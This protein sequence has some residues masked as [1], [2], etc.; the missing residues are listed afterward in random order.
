MQFT[1]ETTIRF[2]GCC[3]AVLIAV[4]ALLSTYK[5]WRVSSGPSIEA[6][7]LEREFLQYS[8][9]KSYVAANGRVCYLPAA[10]ANFESK[11]AFFIA[12]YALAPFL[13]RRGSDC[14]FIVVDRSH[15]PDIPIPD[16]STLIGKFGREVFLLRKNASW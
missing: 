10:D 3:F 4:V 8:S 5:L 6:K 9:L 13:L 2:L 15:A 14:E 12:Q 7:V 16:E 11:R 1:K